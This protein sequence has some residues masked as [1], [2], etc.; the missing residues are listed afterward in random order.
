MNL[1]VGLST[2]E[3]KYKEQIFE[4][5]NQVAEDLALIETETYAPEILIEYKNTLKASTA[6]ANIRNRKEQEKIEKERLIG[7]RTH[8]RTSSLQSLTLIY[9]DLTKT[10]HFVSDENIFVKLSDVETLENDEWTKKYI[11]LEFAVKELKKNNISAP[12]V[13]AQTPQLIGQSAP[14]E[15]EIFTATFEVTGTHSKLAMLKNF[16]IENNFNYKNL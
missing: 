16:L 15:E 1:E 7:E 8:K 14:K 12:K 10:Y 4:F 2:S 11:E 3:K 5:V 9:S 6:I 13:K